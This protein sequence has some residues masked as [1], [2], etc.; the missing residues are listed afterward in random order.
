MKSISPMKRP[1]AV[2]EN[3]TRLT[4]YSPIN[5]PKPLINYTWFY[6]PVYY[7]IF[8]IIFLSPFILYLHGGTPGIQTAI[9]RQYLLIFMQIYIYFQAN[10]FQCKPMTP[11]MIRPPQTNPLKY[12][13]PKTKYRKNLILY[14]NKF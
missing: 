1:P 6:L 13:H 7:S 12:N 9:L 10:C 3:R 11:K 5:S 2:K 8:L 14:L 4:Y